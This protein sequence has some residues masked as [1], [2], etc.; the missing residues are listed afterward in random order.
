MWGQEK[1]EET[2]LSEQDGSNVAETAANSAPEGAG[3]VIAF[4]GKGVEFKGTIS[5]SELP[6]F[7]NNKQSLKLCF[8]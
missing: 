7:G 5:Y 4:V 8:T 3:D 1:K 2:G 6:I